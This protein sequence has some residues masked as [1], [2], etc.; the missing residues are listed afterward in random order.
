MSTA[1]AKA[2]WTADEAFLQSL[3]Q[4]IRMFLRD[5]SIVYGLLNA[6]AHSFRMRSLDLVL[7]ILKFYAGL[8]RQFLECASTPE[9]SDQ[10]IG[11]H[12][13]RFRG[14]LVFVPHQPWKDA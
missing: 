12:T 14:D 5:R 7:Y 3:E 1:E 4:P 13:E 9:G 8:V 11:G 6:F 10:L 2:T